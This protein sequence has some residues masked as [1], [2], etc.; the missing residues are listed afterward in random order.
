LIKISEHLSKIHTIYPNL[1]KSKSFK[2]YQNLSN[3]FKKIETIQTIA[4]TNIYKIYQNRSKSFK[5]DQNLS[6]SIKIYQNLS[7]F[8]KIYKSLSKSIKYI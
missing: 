7:T 4:L 2:I 1:S 6:K 8:L 5:I 3:I